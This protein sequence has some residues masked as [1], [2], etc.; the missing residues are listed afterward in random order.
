M[1]ILLAALVVGGLAWLVRSRDAAARRSHA[2]TSWAPTRPFEGRTIPEAQIAGGRIVVSGLTKHYQDAKAVDDLSFAVEPGR[3]TGFLGPNGAGKTTTLRMLLGLVA[4]TA[5]TATI[6]GIR[7]ADLDQP[8]R[9]VGGVLEASAAHK[10]RTGRDHLRIICRASGVP[11][12]RAD[13]VL[14]ATGLDPEGIR[15]MRDLLRALAAGGRTVLLSSHVLS[16]V[17]LLA[18]DVY[19]HA[20]ILG[21]PVIAPAVATRAMITPGRAFPHAPPQWAG[22]AVMAGN[23]LVFGAIGIALTQ[24]RDVT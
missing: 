18:D 2:D 8:A 1:V 20:W 3:V 10:G 24:R 14:E 6:G 16:E 21:A 19:R 11:L 17:E 5:G 7:Y 9:R 22:L 15:W 13:E 12:A 4:P 23:A